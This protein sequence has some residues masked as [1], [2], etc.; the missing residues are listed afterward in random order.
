LDPAAWGGWTYGPDC[1][2]SF[3]LYTWWM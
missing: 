2:Y 3:I 1:L